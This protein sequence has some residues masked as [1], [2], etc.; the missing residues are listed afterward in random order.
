MLTNPSRSTSINSDWLTEGCKLTASNRT[1]SSCA[2][3]HLT[4]FA[5]LA[6]P[7]GLVGAGAS[8]S[9]EPQVQLQAQLP[10]ANLLELAG[11]NQQQQ[12]QK[13]QLDSVDNELSLPSKTLY[14]AKVS[15][16]AND[17]D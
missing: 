15:E 14:L 10:P 16:L 12:Q 5:L 8:A 3:N 11:Q 6:D 17:D 7:A 2:C 1:H 9:D 4:S 13:V